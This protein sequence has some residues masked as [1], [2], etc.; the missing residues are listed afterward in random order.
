MSAETETFWQGE[1]GDAYHGRNQPDWHRKVPFFKRILHATGPIGSVLEVGCGPGWNLR[2]LTSADSTME[3]AGCDIN[4]LAIANAKDAL[5]WADFDAMPANEIGDFYEGWN[6]EMVMTAGVLIH[7]PPAEIIDV[8]EDITELATTWVLAIEYASDREEEIEY[9]GHAGRL[10]KRPYD[11]MYEHFGLK[12]VSTEQLG[13]EQGFGVG[14]TSW[15][16][17]KF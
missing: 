10:W 17:K 8:M 13:P 2:A 6:F 14:C 12:V 4:K 16:L 15:L 7:I 5:P 3:L 11:K 1:F 9:R